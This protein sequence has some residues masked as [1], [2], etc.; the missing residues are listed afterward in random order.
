MAGCDPIL[1]SDSGLDPKPGLDVDDSDLPG[2][3]ADSGAAEETE[4]TGS[5]EDTDEYDG[6]V[7]RFTSCADDSPWGP[8][9]EECAAEYAGTTLEG[10]VTLASGKQRWMV[11]ET[12]SY[13][14]AAKG[15]D[16]GIPRLTES[17]EG[18][19]CAHG[20]RGAYTCGQFELTAG[21][22]L[23][24]AV[25]QNARGSGGGGG[26]F[27]VD[28]TEAPLVVAGGGGGVNG[29]SMGCDASASP[30]GTGGS[31]ITDP[32]SSRCTARESEPGYGGGTASCG[33]SGGGGFYSGG[34]SCGDHSWPY[35]VGGGSWSS[36]L[37]GGTGEVSRSGGFGGGG[38]ANG[39][40]S[41]G[42]GGGGGFCRCHPAEAPQAQGQAQVHRWR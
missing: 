15:A 21:T 31:G 9:M 8:S 32:E 41:A 11:E 38:A 4:D 23:Q 7:A 37:Y 26:T 10:A 14:I 34:G 39:L 25:G 27:V 36:G 35:A 13:Y 1:L 19:D 2:E 17:C 12:A 24:I 18:E 22:V 5:A 3:L 16:G 20:G 30:H 33:S 29:S 42:A 6:W 40:Y 28:D